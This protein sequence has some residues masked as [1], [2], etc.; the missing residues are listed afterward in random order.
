MSTVTLYE[1]LNRVQLLLKK[2]CRL[3][4][5]SSLF[6]DV[7]G[8]VRNWI[9]A[10]AAMHFPPPVRFNHDPSHRINNKNNNNTKL[11]HHRPRLPSAKIESMVVL[12]VLKMGSTSLNDRPSLDDLMS[13]RTTLAELGYF[14]FFLFFMCEQPILLQHLRLAVRWHAEMHLNEFWFSRLK[15]ISLLPRPQRHNELTD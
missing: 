13:T 4:A 6:S 3:L 5:V 15:L 10:A 12:L 14:F 8:V 2:P 7:V 11:C 1:S 9:C